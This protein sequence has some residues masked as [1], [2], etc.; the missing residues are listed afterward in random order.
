MTRPF[1]IALAALA[2][3][4]CGDEPSPLAPPEPPDPLVGTWVAEGVD[5]SIPGPPRVLSVSLTLTLNEDGTATWRVENHTEGDE[6]FNPGDVVYSASG[7]WQFRGQLILLWLE[8]SAR[9]IP[10]LHLSGAWWW[11]HTLVL[12]SRGTTWILARSP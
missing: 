8:D 5:Y 6:I 11:P 1:L 7:L 4:A 12:Q 10:A 2:L 3:M 9:S